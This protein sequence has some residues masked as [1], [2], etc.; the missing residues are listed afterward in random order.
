[1][2]HI[3][4]KDLCVGKKEEENVQ[5]IANG[6]NLSQNGKNNLHILCPAWLN[7]YCPCPSCGISHICV[8]TSLHWSKNQF[9]K[10][11]L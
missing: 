2:G 11:N 3:K 10:K 4:K 6:P 1:M 8:Q 9:Y 5:L 7:L